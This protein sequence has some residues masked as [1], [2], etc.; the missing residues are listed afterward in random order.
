MNAPIRV[1]MT[2]SYVLLLA[3]ILSAVGAFVIL[4]LRTDLTGATDRSLTPAAD[5]I[6]AGYETEGV[7]DLRD[8]ARTVLAGERAAA[9]VLDGSG[10][11]LTAYG[12]VVGTRPMLEGAGLRAV[13]AGARLT[14]TT[15]LAPGDFR[16]VARPVQRGGR[17]LALVVAESL[18][19]VA[20][21]VRR[22]LILLLL[23][24]P[25]ALAA[26]ALAGWWLARRALRPIDRMTSAAEAI[27]PE[28][29]HERVGVPGTADEV[30]HLAATL[31]TMLDRIERG[32]DEQR[33]LVADTS[34]E[35]RTPLAR[36]R[37][38]IDVSLRSDALSPAAREV[39]ESTRDEVDEMNTIVEGLLTLARADEGLLG[40][41]DEDVDLRQLA[42]DAA[43]SLGGEARRLGVRLDLEG[44]PARVR[45]DARR[46]SHVMRNLID[47]AIKF[48]PRDGRVMISSWTS[49]TEAGVQV[50]DEGAGIP[51]DLHERVFDRYF[52]VDGSRA[53][54]T[55]GS[56]LGL[57]I[58]HAVVAAHG[59]RIGV[60]SRAPGGSAFTVTLPASR[61]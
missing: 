26:T 28:R 2:A 46:L 45:G 54:R 59:G 3:A 11:V 55:G 24:L 6:A 25:A 48:S 50:T 35:L 19:P 23:A 36:M 18:A 37:T 49:P 14:T 53:R 15:R 60:E 20:G 10:R 29:L 41:V 34:H 31:N 21:S 33:R 32:V 8:A 57:A 22:V 40:L 16:V 17:R 47:N 1:R 58:A 51:P 42:A 61:R 27:G 12:D 43:A 44:P 38:E 5:Q 39:L 56:G 4:R 30:A 7:K 52:R 13:V 9:Q